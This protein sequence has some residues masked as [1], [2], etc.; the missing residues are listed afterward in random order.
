[1]T[2]ALR[3]MQLP[4]LPVLPEPLRGAKLVVIDGAILADD[5]TAAE[6]L[7][8]LRAYEPAIDTFASVAPGDLIRI[9]GDPEEPMPGMSAS[10]VLK[11]TTSEIIDA[12]VDVAGHES[13][14]PLLFV[15]LRQL[16]GALDRRE[17]AGALGGFDGDFAMFSFGLPMD[18]AMA[19][20]IAAHLAV[21]EAAV[22]PVANG[23]YLN[24]AERPI[25]A[26]TAFA[27]DRYARLQ[28]LRGAVDP[29]G[30]LLPNH[31]IPAV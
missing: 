6:L 13:G 20:G 5:A 18:P 8:P 29:A 15:E 11:D 28:A 3:I 26:A 25:D 22:Q 10:A 21:V 2:T 19:A 16:G 4:P 23:Q 24:F 30:M 7:A 12:L 14:S 27:A 17:D 9:H 31:E 1:M